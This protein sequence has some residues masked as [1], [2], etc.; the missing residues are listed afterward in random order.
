MKLLM[1]T[2]LILVDGMPGTGKSTVAQ[3]IYLRLRGGGVP[4]KWYH[5]EATHPV[6]RFYD[7][8]RHRTWSAYIDDVA[9]RWVRYAKELENRNRID[10]LDAALFQNHVRSMLVFDADR[11][12][13]RDL[14]HRIDA[15]VASICPILI[16]LRPVG[17]E[18]NFRDAARNRGHRMLDLWIEAHDAYPYTAHFRSTGYAAFID[19]WREYEQIVDG[20]FDSLAMSKLRLSASNGNW[21]ERFAGLG[22]LFDQPKNTHARTP[23]GFAR[24]TGDYVPMIADSSPGFQLLVRDDDLLAA[25]SEPTYDPDGSPIVRFKETRLL[26][27]SDNTCHL[28]GWPHVVSFTDNGQA[29]VRTDEATEAG[30]VFLRR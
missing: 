13:I 1:D 6:R 28:V 26:P 4:A 8:K 23:R 12:A 16:Y 14:V 7:A 2:K 5:E 24:F 21:H 17:I 18:K 11:G 29:I 19:F 9:A 22:E 25:V 15:V 3:F 10:V 27:N 20:I 30:D